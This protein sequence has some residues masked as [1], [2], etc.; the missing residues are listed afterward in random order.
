MNP[1]DSLSGASTMMGQQQQHQQQQQCM[2]LY[3]SCVYRID[4]DNPTVTSG[5]GEMQWCKLVFDPHEPHV[6]HLVRHWFR[7]EM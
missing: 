2:R 7:D 3:P 6:F 4:R 1:P 5:S